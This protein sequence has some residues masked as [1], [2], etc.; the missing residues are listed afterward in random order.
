M[1]TDGHGGERK[2]SGVRGQGQEFGDLKPQASS[3][4]S[5]QMDTDR[6][7]KPD[8]RLC[9]GPGVLREGIKARKQGE[10]VPDSI[11]VE[12]TRWE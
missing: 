10:R 3:L 5:L 4:L 9:E 6:A 7:G 2:E 8:L 12:I 1:N 11:G